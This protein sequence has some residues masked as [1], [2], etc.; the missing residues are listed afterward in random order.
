M[1][2]PMK[3]NTTKTIINHNQ[4]DGGIHLVKEMCAD[5]F[6]PTSVWKV[7]ES[8]VVRTRDTF[9]L[10]TLGLFDDN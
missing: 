8:G 2:G 1:K 7:I 10:V 6:E 3:Q 5:T 4:T 9:H